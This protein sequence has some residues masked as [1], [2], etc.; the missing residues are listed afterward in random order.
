MAIVKKSLSK[1]KE[2]LSK[3]EAQLDALLGNTDLAARLGYLDTITEFAGAKIDKAKNIITKEG[4]V[5][6]KKKVEIK[7][8]KARKAKVNGV[9][10]YI[11][12][13]SYR[14]KS[15]IRP[16]EHIA[17]I[18]RYGLEETGLEAEAMDVPVRLIC[19]VIQEDFKPFKRWL[20][21]NY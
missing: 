1:Q 3:K 18:R 10:N 21:I 9:K 11:K 12:I 16:H 2:E 7:E 8:A 6:E 17:I 13:H 19:E 20:D 15:D 14:N 5:I 4:K